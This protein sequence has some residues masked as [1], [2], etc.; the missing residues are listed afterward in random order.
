VLA[1]NLINIGL[2]VFNILPI[3][4]LDGGKILWALLWYPLGRARSLMIAVVVGF[5]GVAGVVLLAILIQSLWL[6]ILAAFAGMQCYRGF[7]QAQLLQRFA[8]LPRREEFTC[9]SCKASPPRGSFW[10]CGTCNAVFD[11]FESG[12]VC[13]NCSMHFPQTACPNCGTFSPYSEWTSED[14]VAANL[15]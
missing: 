8:E 7:K 10:G 2:L 5:I 3:Y 4:P 14:R 13:P 15:P 12:G 9:P 11:T 1:L 6:G